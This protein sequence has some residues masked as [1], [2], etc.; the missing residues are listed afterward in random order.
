MRVNQA[1][2]E[3]RMSRKTADELRAILDAPEGQYSPEARS[4]ATAAL[5]RVPSDDAAPDAPVSS[6]RV[7]VFA[8]I[9]TIVTALLVGGEFMRFVA[10]LLR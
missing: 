3:E 6:P 7:S 4:A 9:A 1:E 10:H 5:A 2:I 8:K